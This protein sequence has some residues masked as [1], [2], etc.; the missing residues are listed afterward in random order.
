MQG[1]HLGSA[2]SRL[3]GWRAPRSRGP[4][5]L[6]HR[7]RSRRDSAPQ[8]GEHGRGGLE[9]QGR[10]RRDERQIRLA[11]HRVDHRRDPVPSPSAEPGRVTGP[12]AVWLYPHPSG[13]LMEIPG[14]VRWPP[15]QGSHRARR[16]LLLGHRAVLPGRCHSEL[17][18][19][20]RRPRGRCAL[21]QPA[22]HPEP[23]RRDPR[24]G[25][26]PPA[27]LTA[28]TGG[29][30]TAV[31]PLTVWPLKTARSVRSALAARPVPAVPRR[32]ARW[33]DRSTT[34]RPRS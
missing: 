2:A 8:P 28:P 25:G 4:G 15:Q 11:G 13:P 1:H 33:P 18:R 10:R 22:H 14:G 9:A 32:R 21:P 29:T 7:N 6:V 12:I 26:G 23:A 5:S 16:A 27:P 31:T 3:S 20:P 34:P 30:C 17:G 24:R 19:V